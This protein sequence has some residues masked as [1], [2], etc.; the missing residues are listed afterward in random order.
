MHARRQKLRLIDLT[1]AQDFVP[2]AHPSRFLA[3]LQAEVDRRLH[4]ADAADTEADRL[5]GDQR[6][7]ELP[8]WVTHKQGRIGKPDKRI[9]EEPDAKLR[10]V[11][12]VRAEWAL[13]CTAHNLLELP[14]PPE[15]RLSLPHRPGS[16]DTWTGS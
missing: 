15:P 12:K 7:D 2:K 5:H 13:I 9:S 11:D 16:D 4:A 14:S 10:G 3:E 8:E 1:G 6:G